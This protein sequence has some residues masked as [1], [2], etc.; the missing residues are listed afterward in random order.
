[1]RLRVDP[2]GGVRGLYSEAIDLSTLG[3]VSISRASHVEPDDCGR[4][5]A[6]IF[7]G[8]TLGPF[9]L[10]SQALSAEQQWLEDQRLHLARL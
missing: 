6:R 3:L 1:M 9:A 8:P 7:D 2:G 4:W 10:R 5:W